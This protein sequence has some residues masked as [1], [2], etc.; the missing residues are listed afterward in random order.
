MNFFRFTWLRLIALILILLFST[1]AFLVGTQPGSRWLLNTVMAQINGRMLQIEGT[2]WS[3]ISSKELEVKT[4]ALKIVAKDNA[5]AVNWLSLLR[6]RLQVVHLMTG[7]LSIELFPTE[8]QLDEE[9]ADELILPISIQ[10]DKV[11]VGKFTMTDPQGKNLPVGLNNFDLENL[12][13]D[14]SGTKAD[15]HQLTV[16]HPDVKSELSGTVELEKLAYPWPMH[17]TLDT[18]N[19]GLHTQS[20]LCVDYLLGKS[21]DIRIQTRCQIDATVQIDGGLDELQIKL[22]ADG[23]GQSLDLDVD[24][25]LDLE[26]TMPLTKAIIDL[27]MA[28]DMRLQTEINSVPLLVEGASEEATKKAARRLEGTIKTDKFI[29][30][31]IQSGSRLDSDFN[32]AVD[33]DQQAQLEAIEFRGGIFRGS[34]WNLEPLHGGFNINADFSQV[35]VE[36]GVTAWEQ[37][38]LNRADILLRLGENSIE[39]KGQFL[40]SEQA[41]EGLQLDVNLQ[42]LSQ[43][44]EEIAGR[45]ELKVNM[46]GNISEHDIKAQIKYDPEV[47]NPESL[48]AAE[49]AASQHGLGKEAINAHFDLV[50]K[51]RSDEGRYHWQA[52]LDNLQAAHAGFKLVQQGKAQLSFDQTIGDYLFEIAEADFEVTLP[53]QHQGVLHHV[54]TSLSRSAWASEGTFNDLIVDNRLMQLLGLEVNVEA[55]LDALEAQDLEA[56]ADEELKTHQ[57][58]LAETRAAIERKKQ[59]PAVAYDGDWTLK[60]QPDLLGTIHLKRHSGHT[61]L[62]LE[63]PLPLDLADIAIELTQGLDEEVQQTQ[64]KVHGQGERSELNTELSLEGGFAMAVK[65]AAVDLTSTDEGSLKLEIDTVRDLTQEQVQNWQARIEAN[66]LDL[67]A[68][69]LGHLPDESA[70]N[71]NGTIGAT[72]LQRKLIM[73]LQ[74]DLKIESGSRW[75]HFD[76]SGQIKAVADLSGVFALPQQ[77]E[78]DPSLATPKWY[79]LK[80]SD[81]DT[82][83]DLD[84]S[85]LS[86][87]G[88]IGHQDDEL[89]LNVQI[90]ELATWWPGTPG[91]VQADMLL[92]GDPSKHTLSLNALYDAFLLEDKD[93]QPLLVNLDLNGEVR[94]EATKPQNWV[95]SA[96]ALDA[97]YAGL[98]LNNQKPLQI[99]LMLPTDKQ[100]FSWQVGETELSLRYPDGRQ[101]LIHHEHSEGQ[102]KHW[103]TQ[104]AISDLIASMTLYEYLLA[105]VDSL[106]QKKLLSPPETLKPEE[107]LV[108][109]ATW[110]FMQEDQLSGDFHLTRK[111]SSGLWP[112]PTPVPLDFD[113]LSLKVQQTGANA[114]PEEFV[115][116]A[117]GMHIM[118]SGEGENSDLD[119]HVFLHPT[120]PFMLER[121]QVNL[122]L[123]DASSL[124]AHVFTGKEGEF[125]ENTRLYGVLQT[126]GMPLEKIS[127]GAVPP[128]MINGDL[129]FNIILAEDYT[130]RQAFLTGEF[131]QGSRWNSQPLQG[132]IDFGLFFQDQH[133]F[134]LSKADIDLRLG[135]SR[136]VSK[137]AF[138]ERD[139]SLA[140]SVKAPRLSDLWP[141]LPGSVDLDLSLDG[142]I[143]DN[144]LAAKGRFSQGNFNQVGKAPIDFDVRATGG[145]K[146]LQ[147]GYEGWSGVIESLDVKHAGFAVNQHEAVSLS[148]IPQGAEGKPQWDIGASTLSITLPG[149]HKISLEQGGTD[150]QD[151]KFSTQGAIRGLTLT[152]QLIDDVSNAF[153]L[154]LATNNNGK[155]LNHGIIVRG[156]E[157]PITNPPVFDVEWDFDF[158][159]ALAGAANILHR[160]G[161]FILPSD[162]PVR[163]GLQR[164]DLRLN[165]QPQGGQRSLLTA[166]LDLVTQSKGN[167]KGS[168]RLNLD[169]FNPVFDGTTQAHMVG[170]MDDISWLTGLTG[171][172]LE[173]GGRV[174]V[175]VTA[176][177]RGGNWVTSGGVKAQDLRIVEVENGIRLLNGTLDLGL[178]GNDVVINRLHF[179]SVIRIIPNEWRTRQWIEENPPAQNGSLNINGNWNLQ[180]SRGKLNIVLDH[181]PLLQRT[182]RFAMMSGQVT[183]DAA[184]PSIVV[185]GKLTADA[186]W[187]SVDIKGTAPTLDSDVIIVR[188][189]EEAPVAKQSALD[190]LLN[191]TVDLGPR[192]YVVG[193]G[194]DAGLVGAITIKQAN[195]ELSAEGEFNTRGGAIEAYGQRLQIRRG[196]ITFQGD[197]A[198]PV[199]DIEAL[200]RN[201]EVEAGMRV[202]GNARNPKITLVSYPDVSEVEK[203]SWLIMGRGPDSSG[204]DLAMLLTVGTSLLGGDPASEPIHKQL[205]ID[206]ITIRKGDVGESGSILP[207]RTVADSTAYQ[208]QDDISE[209]FIKITKRLRQGIDLSIEQAL[210]GS[211]TVGRVSYTLIRNLTIDAKVGTVSGIEM[212]YRRLF[213]D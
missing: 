36:K 61:I 56:M 69:S 14:H 189:G 9:S 124:N 117:E 160:G 119:A 93:K 151:G 2:I 152:P 153:G 44:A 66:A 143:S 207:R 156:R 32:F 136:I 40:S 37:L 51:L 209:Q 89:K 134:S 197:I 71:I 100:Q 180:S 147:E 114:L 4:P 57:Q 188:K 5:L 115:V 42:D 25:G 154:Q 50:G 139:D 102:S 18:V 34:R 92:K 126:S 167:I 185:D 1:L 132:D 68:F 97:S 85:Y 163:L 181:Y 7:D 118:A 98:A 184:L 161:D 47:P 210:S 192:F 35:F 95:L 83:I 150:G 101:S 186:G 33:F 52:A 135:Q 103:E 205:G 175:D 77:I 208:G 131:L 65:K 123:P 15:L 168:A 62:P 129:H 165:S 211:G 58:A 203:L 179:P 45:A 6:A 113:N 23:V 172:L 144:K 109:D 22:K 72:V 141:T 67:S 201:L 81:V 41:H 48:S 11:S 30:D 88:A 130:P 99:D 162:P 213:K 91:Q 155:S 110:A 49:L 16:T 196:R 80:L 157:T 26:S 43:I 121:A 174:D 82:F 13:L 169:G 70:L 125:E 78:L 176:N 158:D 46:L 199:L 187:V 198:N 170:H 94:F 20:P 24:A 166:E 38:S 212:I 137:G 171:D 173:L 54:K 108:F 106:Q 149:N 204:G 53:G 111:H 183:V 60:A 122:R 142:T 19:E 55:K 138:G 29:L 8:P 59:V 202:V 10:V 79:Q 159:G 104:G 3:G 90:P 146:N 194:L 112:F 63:H 127:Y 107:E 27:T 140:L 84:R 87:L 116:S 31:L 190:L 86:L 193:F 74:P 75:N 164:M 17:L 12:V 191:F 177:Y 21:G 148:F 76:L 133:N 206:D 178:N 200:R 105:V 64:I 128:G 28:K 39:S 120:S 195:N 145:W 96:R 73:R 182:D